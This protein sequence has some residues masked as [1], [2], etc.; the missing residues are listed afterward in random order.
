MEWQSPEPRTIKIKV[1][2]SCYKSYS[3]VRLGI[4]VRDASRK[5]VQPWAVVRERA[6]NPVVAEVDTVR[7]TFYMDQQNG[8]NKMQIQVDIKLWQKIF[9]LELAQFRK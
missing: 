9:K 6:I 1:S 5:C 8:W 2:S 7:A 3:K 4:I